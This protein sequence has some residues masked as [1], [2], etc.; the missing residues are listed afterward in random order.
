VGERDESHK[1]VG[2]TLKK[3]EDI[4][5]RKSREKSKNS[6]QSEEKLLG[7]T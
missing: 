4:K 1:C 5:Q 6:K 2:R 3:K 7:C